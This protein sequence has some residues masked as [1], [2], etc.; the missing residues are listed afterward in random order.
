M[1][2]FESY[3]EEVDCPCGNKATQYWDGDMD[4]GYICS[5]SK[6]DYY[7]HEII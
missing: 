2:D 7:P 3:E 6:C 5:N 4:D 1:N